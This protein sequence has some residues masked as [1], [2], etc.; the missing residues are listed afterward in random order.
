MNIQTRLF[1]WSVLLNI[2]L[3]ISLFFIFRANSSNQ[4]SAALDRDRLLAGNAHLKS[5]LALRD[6][7]IWRIQNDRALDSTMHASTQGGLKTQIKGLKRRLANSPEFEGIKTVRDTIILKQD[8]LITD[9]ENER[10][11][12]RL[13]F[14]E[15]IKTLG[16]SRLALETAYDSTFT[17]LLTTNDKLIVS[18]KKLSRMEKIAKA[19]GISTVVLAIVTV[20]LLL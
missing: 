7:A 12:I 14:Q 13:S 2:A 3:I 17:Q 15:E 19:L 4:Q 16:Q 1:P 9:L 6:T 10:D 11:S 8:T 18:E 5:E 20:I